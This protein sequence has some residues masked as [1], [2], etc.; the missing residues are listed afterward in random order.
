MSNTLMAPHKLLYNKKT[1]QTST[2]IL[3]GSRDPSDK[4]LR[5][6][7]LVARANST[8]QYYL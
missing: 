4:K 7:F 8:T 1:K 2:L 5:D 3:K 6:K